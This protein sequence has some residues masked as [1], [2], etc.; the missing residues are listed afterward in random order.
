MGIFFI[1]VGLCG[2]IYSLFTISSIND[3]EKNGIQVSAKIISYE[4][5][6]E[7]YKTPIISFK[8]QEGDEIQKEPNYYSSS[9]LNK[10]KNHKKDINK[11][12][13]IKYNPKNPE[14]F[15]LKDDI[16]TFIIHIL[17]LVVCSVFIIIGV[18][19]CFAIKI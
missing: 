17:L 16:M 12:V 5:D 2:F 3:L 4:S 1:I 13:Q 7:G 6:H 18:F 19:N 15:M 11:T 10:I 9:D 8:T 14:I